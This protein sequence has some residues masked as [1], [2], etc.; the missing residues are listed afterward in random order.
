MKSK[1]S[2]FLKV[3]K[4]V[5]ERNKKFLFYT[6]GVEFQKTA[7][8]E[9]EVVFKRAVKLKNAAIKN[10]DEESA[11]FLLSL[12]GL[13]GAYINELKMLVYL[14]EDN[15]N[16][17]WESLVNAQ[18]SLRLAFQA[19]PVGSTLEGEDYVQKLAFIEKLFFPPQMFFSIGGVVSLAECAI[20]GQEY[21]TCNHIKGKA[22]MG[23]I[24]HRVIK[25]FKEA[26]DV[27]LVTAPANKMC[28]V[29]NLTSDDGMW[30]DFLTWR[31]AT[32][33]EQTRPTN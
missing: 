8:A 4:E 6:R 14:K 9:L 20:C 13:V 5:T 19:N 10:N 23:Q 11:N 15:S 17:A 28:R 30:R 22:Y 32:K 18:S 7:I 31:A 29:T 24:C 26:N 21:G 3:F 33:E 2:I 16:K 27:S 1:V 25:E 12:E